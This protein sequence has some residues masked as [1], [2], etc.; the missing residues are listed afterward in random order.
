MAKR[1]VAVAFCVT[2]KVE[3][4]FV[5]VPNC[6][7]SF[8]IEDDAFETKPVLKVPRPVFVMVKRSVV[9]PF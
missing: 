5:V 8:E 2:K 9:G 4:A 3:V 6:T 1:F 7:E